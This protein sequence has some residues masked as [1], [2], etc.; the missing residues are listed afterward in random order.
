M[1]VVT[2]AS[3]FLGRAVVAELAARELPAMAVSRGKPAFD[4]PVQTL[5]VGHYSQVKPV[6]A[7]DVLLHLAEPRH[8]GTVEQA[9]AQYATEM[10]EVVSALA[11][12]GWAHVVYASSAA[13]YSDEGKQPH[14]ADEPIRP[15]G[16]YAQ[17]KAAC[18]DIALRAGGGA[19]RLANLYG[20][21]M[22]SNNVMSDILAQIGKAGPIRVRDAKPVRDY[23]W[24]EDAARG[25]VNASVAKL[26]GP[27]NLASGVGTSVNT[28]AMLILSLANERRSLEETAPAPRESHLVLDIAATTE[29]LGWRPTV[30]LRQGLARLVGAPA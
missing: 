10:R 28:L 25:L 29:R 27:F 19:A 2:G 12:A 9:G 5:Q 20:S 21:G 3:G 7:G 11:G 30:P 15:R 22:A 24:I 1:F 4:S 14:R 13:V 16:A 23:L 17:T 18:E 26:A 8:I 6:G